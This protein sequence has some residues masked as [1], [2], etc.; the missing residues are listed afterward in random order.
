MVY[1]I[2]SHIVGGHGP[3]PCEGG[4][5]GP[6][7]LAKPFASPSAKPFAKHIVAETANSLTVVRKGFAKG[8]RKECAKDLA[9]QNMDTLERN[10]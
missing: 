7:P 1:S 5:M 6:K 4:G 10:K 3:S 8:L 2:C 9:P